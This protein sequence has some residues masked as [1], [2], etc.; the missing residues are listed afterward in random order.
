MS[1]APDYI[2]PLVAWRAWLVTDDDQGIRLRSVVFPTAWSPG[3]E[4][5]AECEQR[6]RQ[7]LRP[8]R[9]REGHPAP[10][11]TCGCGI[12]GTSETGTLAEYLRRLPLVGRDDEFV[13]GQAIGR[14]KL[15][16][17]VVEHTLGWRASRA[18]PADL[19]VPAS[20]HAYRIGV[21]LEVYDVPV[22]V[23]DTSARGSLLDALAKVG[24]R[25]LKRRLAQ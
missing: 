13:I 14:V 23:L 20:P 8:W 15:W 2:E 3:S 5:E 21:G 11:S 7:L 24:T 17:S 19:F 1:A 25:P 22:E 9:R 12:Y 4:L 6:S 10:S 16:G 18:Y